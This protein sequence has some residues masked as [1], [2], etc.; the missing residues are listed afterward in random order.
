[1]AIRA[2]FVVNP[3]TGNTYATTRN[4]V[5][6]YQMIQPGETARST[7]AALRLVLDAAYDVYTVVDG[8]RVEMTPGDVVLTHSARNGSRRPN[9][10]AQ[11]RNRQGCDADDRIA[12]DPTAIRCCYRKSL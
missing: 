2:T 3:A 9:W 8:K 5:G 6:A 7:P 4:I 12:R 1:L 11:R 10:H